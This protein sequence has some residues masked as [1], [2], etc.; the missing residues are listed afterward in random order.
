[1][2]SEVLAPDFQDAVCRVVRVVQPLVHCLNDMM[3]L[4][5]AGDS[6]SDGD[7]Q[8]GSESEDE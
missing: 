2:D 1:M 3:T 7:E 6:D 5:D 4:Q 8:A